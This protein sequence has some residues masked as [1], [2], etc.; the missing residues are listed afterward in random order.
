MSGAQQ[1]CLQEQVFTGQLKGLP[2]LLF[3]QPSL[4]LGFAA[5]VCQGLHTKSSMREN[6]SGLG[7]GLSQEVMQPFAPGERV[8]F[9]GYFLCGQ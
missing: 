1:G 2:G 6:M 3:A 5:H 7:Q 8:S 9:T 4:M